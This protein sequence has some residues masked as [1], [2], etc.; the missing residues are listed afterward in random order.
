ASASSASNVNVI[1]VKVNG[2]SITVPSRPLT[3]ADNNKFVTVE[4]TGIAASGTNTIEFMGSAA[5]NT[6]GMRLDNLVVI[7]VK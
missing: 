6:L 3:N 5:T 2:T 1:G 7:G 4:L